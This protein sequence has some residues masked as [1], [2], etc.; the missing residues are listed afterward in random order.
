MVKAQEIPS[1]GSLR[2]RALVTASHLQVTF[3]GDAFRLAAELTRRLVP[4]TY[5][6]DV[7]IQTE[8]ALAWT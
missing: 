5:L 2:F 4:E 8:W 6:R 1:L 7:Q 3:P